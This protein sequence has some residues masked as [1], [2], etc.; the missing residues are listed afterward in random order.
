MNRDK[1]DWYACARCGRR[2]HIFAPHNECYGRAAPSKE[3][4]TAMPK[5]P[6]S[7]V[8]LKPRAAKGKED[9]LAVLDE[10]RTAV[11][12]GRIEAFCAV[13]I[14]PGDE[15][16]LYSGACSG[17]TRLRMMGAISALQHCYASG[18]V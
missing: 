18:E 15:T 3:A 14:E 5:P 6:I 17:V 16:L 10:L 13:G 9:M 4:D 1:L 12:S 2:A 8:P 7:L 11:E